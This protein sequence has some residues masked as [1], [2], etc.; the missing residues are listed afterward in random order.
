MR[1]GGSYCGDVCWCKWGVLQR[2][3][4]EV[5]GLADVG[6][7]CTVPVHIMLCMGSR[8]SSQRP[9]NKNKRHI[10]MGKSVDEPGVSDDPLGSSI[11]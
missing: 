3:S 1:A 11:V 6:V 5:C 9:Q 8:A 2:K 4:R 10:S 7:L